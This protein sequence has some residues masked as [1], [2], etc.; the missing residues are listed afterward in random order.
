MNVYLDNLEMELRQQG[1]S[2]TNSNIDNTHKEDKELQ[3]ILS[4]EKIL[5]VK[6][7]DEQ[8][9]ILQHKGNSVILAC[10]G[11]GK[12]LVNGTG[13]LTPRGYINIEDLKVGDIVFDHTGNEQVILGVFPQGKKRVY[14]VKFNTDDII[15]SC[16]EHL[17]TVQRHI[18]NLWQTMTTVEIKSYIDHDNRPY[19]VPHNL[20]IFDGNYKVS[21]SNAYFELVRKSV[22]SYVELGHLI[23]MHEKENS[24]LVQ[25]YSKC[26]DTYVIKSLYNIC[27]ADSYMIAQSEEVKCALKIA[28]EFFGMSTYYENGTQ[29]AR[30][31]V[32]I[33]E[34]NE[35]KEM[36]CIKV[37]GL[38]ELFLTEHCIPTHNTTISTHLIAK[39][40]LTGEIQDPSKLIYMTYSKEGAIEMDTRMK[41]VISKV[42]NKDKVGYDITIDVRTIHSLFYK[43]MRD[44]GMTNKVLTSPYKLVLEA[45]KE[46]GFSPKEDDVNS[47]ISLMG[48]QLNNLLGVKKAFNCVHNNIEDLTLEQYTNIRKLYG[49]K[50]HQMKVIDFDDMQFQLYCWIVAWANSENETQRAYAEQV[51]QYCRY[52]FQHIYI[53]EAQDISKIQFEIIKA[54][55]TDSNNPNKLL[56]NI[57]FIGDD[58]QCI[59]EWRGSDPSIIQ[60]AGPLFNIKTM[61][62]STNYRCMNEIV[63]FATTGI[64]CNNIRYEKGMNAYVNGGS[65][66]ICCVPSSE[67]NLYNMSVR[68]FKKID[69]WIKQGILASNIAVLCRNNKQLSVL[70]AML[71]NAGIYYVGTEEMKVTK[72]IAY[73][74][75]TM[76]IE[77]CD[78]TWKHDIITQLFW[79][80]NKYLGQNNLRYISA[81]MQEAYV[82]IEDGLWYICK[83][84]MHRPIDIEKKLSIG[85]EAKT[86]V[87]YAMDKIGRSSTNAETLYQIYCA[88]TMNDK[89]NRF[90]ALLALYKA[91]MDNI[92]MSRDKKRD[93]YSLLRYM[94]D[95][96]DTLGFDKMTEYLRLVEQYES[97]KVGTLG[98]KVTLSTIHSAK[99][100]EWQ[101]VIMFACDNISE[102]SFDRIVTLKNSDKTSSEDLSKYIDEERRLFYVGSTRAKEELILM[103]SEHPSVFLLESLGSGDTNTDI[104][105]YALDGGYDQVNKHIIDKDILNKESKYYYEEI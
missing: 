102:P 67:T 64:K 48:Y 26:K 5:G 103:T 77:L 92:E 54:I 59:Y 63:D 71:L 93:A 84:I 35:F 101:K 82:S 53:D 4:M 74:D 7:S 79:K 88:I 76:L 83:H 72:G 10:A 75:L 96:S 60:C 19:I 39:R 95:I 65:V 17:W 33:E 2:G 1:I 49:E 89:Q 43:L 58:D 38:S 86:K 94:L 8:R 23:N 40:I 55:I 6:Y 36:T 22:I 100:R 18:D 68:S 16:G 73:K 97:G 45:C 28:Y 90:K 24:K 69:S 91:G 25:I 85:E 56:C 80:F 42:A 21:C 3:T 15:E 57:T 29:Y 34:T 52:M 12:A 14:K 51:K 81:F 46:S 11:S 105:R 37:S 30:A 66:K 31:I 27:L 70:S 98:E 87:T 61:V 9:D 41:K 50:K 104:V 44:F 32:N 62:L 20:D 78:R 47:I 99:G 13:V